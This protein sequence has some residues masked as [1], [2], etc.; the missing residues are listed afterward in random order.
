MKRFVRALIVFLTLQVI[1]FVA[2]MSMFYRPD[3]HQYLAA[4]VMKH[5][6]LAETPA[7][8]LIFV[9]ASNLP[10][11]LNSEIIARET[12]YHPINMGLA[13]NLGVQ[14]HL[15][16]LKPYLRP[17]D[18]VVLSF[19]YEWFSVA[20]PDVDV[21]WRLLEV[22]PALLWRL[23]RR[24]LA[25]ILPG[26][27]VFG[28]IGR[29]LRAIVRTAAGR[30][31]PPGNPFPISAFNRFGDV[32]AH[33]S[34]PVPEGR[35]LALSFGPEYSTESA[36]MVRRFLRLVAG[37]GAH[38]FYLFPP[39]PEEVFQDPANA[40]FTARVETELRDQLGIRILNR[41]AEVVLP[42]ER[43]FDTGYHLTGP[44]VQRYSAFVATKLRATLSGSDIGSGQQPSPSRVERNAG[45]GSLR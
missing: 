33:W 17:D 21:V 28:Y 13:Y 14:F 35:R 7:P 42:S 16:E 38:A 3:R 9:G 12:G 4:S 39:I 19:P 29:V 37:R 34:M 44:G 5:A 45:G 6:L 43:F 8:R 31:L 1:F 11:S 2:A 32:V 18:V 20:K 22:H 10:F 24:E 23:D 40:Q 25:E 36:D 41:P 27:S 26:Q 30:P 15:A